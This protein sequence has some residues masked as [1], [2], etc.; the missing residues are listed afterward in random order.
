MYMSPATTAGTITT[1]Y[2]AGAAEAV[3]RCI[4]LPGV[5]PTD[6]T[7]LLLPVLFTEHVRL[8]PHPQDTTVEEIMAA[9]GAEDGKKIRFLRIAKAV[10]KRYAGKTLFEKRSLSPLLF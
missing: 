5:P 10:V 6:T 7:E 1:T 4:P 9:T 8:L 2:G 3:V